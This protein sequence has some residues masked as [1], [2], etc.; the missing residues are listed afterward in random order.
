[1]TDRPDTPESPEIAEV[2][3]LLADARHTEPMPDDVADRMNAL[4]ARLGDETPAA[5]AEGS[6]RPAPVVPIAAHRRR[7][8]ASLL[9]AAAAIV[10]GG[11]AVAPHI[12][13]GSSGGSAATTAGEDRAAG[14]SSQSLGSTGSDQTRSPEAVQPPT[15]HLPPVQVRDGRVVVRPQHFSTDALQARQ[16]LSSMSLDAQAHRLQCA[17]VPTDAPTVAAEYLNA[18]AALVFRR[19]QG[20]SQVVDLYVCGD[21]RPI[22]SAT[23]PAP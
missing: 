17:D 22:R 3:R 7:R 10:V 19:A 13:G 23:L 15:G 6:P 2:R 4:L 1:M 14:Q 21:A 8:A 5:R 18:P 9:V 12:H 11:V 20:S 16:R